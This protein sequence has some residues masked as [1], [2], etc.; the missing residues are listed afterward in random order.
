MAL[1][2]KKSY[3]QTQLGKKEPRNLIIFFR[4]HFSIPIQWRRATEA[5]E[6]TDM[7]FSVGPLPAAGFG[8]LNLKF[9]TGTGEDSKLV[10]RRKRPKVDALFSSLFSDA[11]ERRV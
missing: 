8:S 11:T 6:I 3:G 7:D 1:S 4:N 2:S 5:T 10:H 9:L